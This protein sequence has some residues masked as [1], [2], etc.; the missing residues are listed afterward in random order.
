MISRLIACS[1]IAL[2]LAGPAWARGPLL[3]PDSTP[4]NLATIDPD[5]LRARATHGE[6]AAAA[7]LGTLYAHGWKLRRDPAEAMRWLM[8][9]ADAEEQAR[10]AGA[11]PVAAAGDGV[12]AR[13]RPRRSLC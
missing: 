10:P 9:A 3:L 4:P 1:C 5:S 6:A 8:H 2:S 11:W 7:D 12:A 13:S